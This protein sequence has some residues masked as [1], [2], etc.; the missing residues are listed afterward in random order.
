MQS[1]NFTQ[2]SGESLDKILLEKCKEHL[3]EKNEFEVEWTQNRNAE[4]R[5]LNECNRVKEEFTIE[6][7][8]AIYV[9]SLVDD[10]DM[11]FD[12]IGV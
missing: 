7:S 12:D 8:A 3:L 5:L 6:T 9:R 2:I 11:I 4:K 1:K 10:K